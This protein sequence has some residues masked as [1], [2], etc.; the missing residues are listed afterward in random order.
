MVYLKLQNQYFDIQFRCY[1][2]F[3]SRNKIITIPKLMYIS[4]KLKLGM[5]KNSM[6]SVTFP[7]LFVNKF[8]PRSDKLPIAPEII[9]KS[10]YSSRFVFVELLN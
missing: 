3:N 5:N 2:F 4:A 7:L 9:N 1:L 10:P 6:K 8:Q